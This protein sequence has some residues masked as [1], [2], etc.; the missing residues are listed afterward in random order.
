MKEVNVGRCRVCGAMRALRMEIDYRKD[1][2]E[3]LP[4]SPA[5]VILVARCDRHPE[6]DE[7]RWKIPV[8]MDWSITPEIL[9]EDAINPGRAAEEE[10]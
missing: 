7:R 6:D 1:G 5:S 4:G 2:R 8:G 9:R 10:G 3:T